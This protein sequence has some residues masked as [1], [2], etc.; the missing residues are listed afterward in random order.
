MQYLFRFKGRSSE[1]GHLR[2]LLVGMMGGSSVVLRSLTSE[3]INGT[4]VVEVRADLLSTGRQ[5]AALEQIVN[6]LSLE[7]SVTAV[8]WEL[9]PHARE[10]E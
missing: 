3:D 7:P 8:T 4:G 9:V 5:D 10:T 1:E 6:R 2:S